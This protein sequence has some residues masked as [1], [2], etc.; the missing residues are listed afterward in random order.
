MQHVMAPSWLLPVVDFPV[1]PERILDPILPAAIGRAARSAAPH[2][3]IS[4]AA[5]SCL[6][7]ACLMG[8]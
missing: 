5:P 2:A 4:E 8:R 7:Y 6:P 1:R 3:S